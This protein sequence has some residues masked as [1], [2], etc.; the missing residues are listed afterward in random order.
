MTDPQAAGSSQPVD[1]PQPSTPQAEE[2]TSNLNAHTNT[3]P[4]FDYH[5]ERRLHLND[6]IWLSHHLPRLPPSSV[7][8]QSGL[9]DDRGERINKERGLPS[10]VAIREHANDASPSAFHPTDMTIDYN[11][12]KVKDPGSGASMTFSVLDEGGEDGDDGEKHD[13]QHGS[14]PRSMTASLH[15]PPPAATHDVR[16]RLHERL[17]F[18]EEQDEREVGRSDHFPSRA[19]L[20]GSQ[21]DDARNPKV[22]RAIESQSGERVL[23]HSLPVCSKNT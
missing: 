19:Y 11:R 5:D 22:E 15:L 16:R 12:Y 18:E 9:S 7:S 4:S 1:V 10:Q 13:G 20:G 8:N 14:V 23:R 2:Y 6:E 21:G 17:A 3:S